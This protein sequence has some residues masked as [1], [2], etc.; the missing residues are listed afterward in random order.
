MLAAETKL[1]RCL[2][3]SAISLR[4]RPTLP[5]SRHQ[6]AA[7]ELPHRI[8]LAPPRRRRGA[9]AATATAAAAT[10]AAAEHLGAAAAHAARAAVRRAAAGHDRAA[11]ARSERRD[12]LLYLPADHG[13]AHAA[14]SARFRPVRPQR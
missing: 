9:A 2:R 13:A 10:G 7:H 6:D 3:D 5:E 8:D 12:D 4:C 14:G 1:L 11:L